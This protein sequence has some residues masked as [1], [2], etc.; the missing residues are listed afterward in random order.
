MAK[1]KGY[2]EWPGYIVKSY[3]DSLK[4]VVFYESRYEAVVQT[5]YMR[6]VSFELL[7][8]A[9]K[10]EDNPKL[11]KALSTAGIKLSNKLES[12]KNK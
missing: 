6:H 8:E 10:K 9:N 11:Q 4:K 1:I 5:K 2:P 7:R 3:S 12:E